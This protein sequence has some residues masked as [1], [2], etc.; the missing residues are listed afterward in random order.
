MLLGSFRDLGR[1]SIGML[2]A[3]LEMGSRWFWD[4]SG[5]FEEVL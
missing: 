3:A 2:E 4:L 5:I 1:D